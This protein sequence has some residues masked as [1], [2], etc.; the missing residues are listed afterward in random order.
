M[1]DPAIL[2]AVL[3][4]AFVLFVGAIIVVTRRDRYDTRRDRPTRRKGDRNDPT[5]RS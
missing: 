5:I 1:P 4:M 3:A 2:L